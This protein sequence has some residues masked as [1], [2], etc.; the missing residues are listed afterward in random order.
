MDV[1]YL[2]GVTLRWAWDV[3]DVRGIAV[4]WLNIQQPCFLRPLSQTCLTQP[5]QKM[6][7]IFRVFEGERLP[8]T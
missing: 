8:E 3:G 6:L 1:M 7:A 2:R 5:L 4:E